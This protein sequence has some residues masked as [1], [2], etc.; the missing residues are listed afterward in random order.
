MREK[1]QV[2]AILMASMGVVVAF[3]YHFS[4]WSIFTII[5]ALIPLLLVAVVFLWRNLRQ[6]N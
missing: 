5:C 6:F 3:V 2:F 4:A 1:M